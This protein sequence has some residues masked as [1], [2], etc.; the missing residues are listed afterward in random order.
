V[1]AGVLA[2]VLRQ[3]RQGGSEGFLYFF[4]EEKRPKKY[5]PHGVHA[6]VRLAKKVGVRVPQIRLT[7]THLGQPGPA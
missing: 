2:A 5:P 7:P 1:G 3:F 6:W 4:S